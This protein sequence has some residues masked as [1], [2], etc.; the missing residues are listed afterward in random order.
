MLSIQLKKD[1]KSK[2][3]DGGGTGGGKSIDNQAKKSAIDKKSKTKTKD[4]RTKDDEERIPDQDYGE[5]PEPT[6]SAKKRREQQL[7]KEKK[8]K[9]QK[10]FY[11]SK[12]DEDDTLGM[13]TTYII[14]YI[15]NFQNPSSL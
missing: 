8:D 4:E 2:L 9:I 1:E 14:K 12:S 7:E 5:I 11:Q 15:N 10:G 13:S 6:A 3:G